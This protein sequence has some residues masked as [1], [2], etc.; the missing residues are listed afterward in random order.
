M[1]LALMRGVSHKEF[2]R[3]TSSREIGEYWALHKIDP[4]FDGPRVEQAIAGLSSLTFNM[5]RDPDKADPMTAA[6][7]T[8]DHTAWLTAKTPE[9]ASDEFDAW[10]AEQKKKGLIQGD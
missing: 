7:F 9:Q 10:H 8:P 3:T 2:L 5:A 6:D 1:R 4:L